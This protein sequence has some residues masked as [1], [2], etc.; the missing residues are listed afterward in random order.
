MGRPD[1]G[2]GVLEMNATFERVARALTALVPIHAIDAATGQRVHISPAE[3]RECTF[4]F[5]AAV[6]VSAHG[7]VR[8][9]VRIRREHLF[10]AIEALQQSGATF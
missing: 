2:R 10:T 7:K 4:A 8:R 1:A 3:A 6:V 5:G 9:R